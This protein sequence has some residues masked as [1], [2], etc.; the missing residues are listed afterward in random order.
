[1][2]THF[3]FFP[4][5][6][7]FPRLRV[8]VVDDTAVA[9]AQPPHGGSSEASS[10]YTAPPPLRSGRDDPASRRHLTGVQLAAAIAR[11]SSGGVSLPPAYSRAKSS[12]VDHEAK[13]GDGEDEGGSGGSDAEAGGGLFHSAAGAAAAGAPVIEVRTCACSAFLPAVTALYR[14]S[15]LYY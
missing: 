3:V 8:T 4:H 9:S 7:S 12:L 1:V 11:S 10:A 15:E 14:V 13:A 6:Q 2:L 5:L